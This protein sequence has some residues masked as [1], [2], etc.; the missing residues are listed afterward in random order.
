MLFLPWHFLARK[1]ERRQKAQLV[2]QPLITELDV[3]GRLARANVGW[4]TA[5]RP[6]DDVVVG[7][8]LVTDDLHGDPQLL[9]EGWKDEKP[10]VNSLRT[11]ISQI[12]PED[13]SRFQF[14]YEYDFG[15]GW[16]H[17]ILFEGCLRAEKGARYPL[18]VEGERAC[19]PEDVGGVGAYREYLETLSDPDHEQWEEMSDWRGP[20]RPEHFDA[21]AATE[22]MRRGLPNWRE[23]E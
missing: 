17:E 19:P 3:L 11:R 12:V 1:P 8:Q 20:C 18:C 16:E 22:A 10:P 2:C 14:E 9:Y 15:D 7:L 5:Q 4:Q 13:G 23:M 6:S 21:A